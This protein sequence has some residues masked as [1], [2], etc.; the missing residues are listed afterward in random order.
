MLIPPR[1]AVN[2]SQKQVLERFDMGAVCQIKD[3]DE[4]SKTV[5]WDSSIHAN[6]EIKSL[7]VPFCSERCCMLIQPRANNGAVGDFIQN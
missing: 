7:T 6:S 3:L 2:A 5:L 4:H 1:A